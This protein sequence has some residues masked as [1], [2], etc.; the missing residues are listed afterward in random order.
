[1][2]RAVAWQK[3]HH[4][5]P[6][7]FVRPENI[8]VTL[9]PPWREEDPARAA[10]KVREAI[11]GISPFDLSFTKICAGPNRREPRLIWTEAVE[12][13]AAAELKRRLNAALQND[14]GRPYRP[15]VT[16]GRLKT[17]YNSDVLAR[18]A[19]EE[20]SWPERVSSV[21]LFETNSDGSPY[22]VLDAISLEEKH[23]G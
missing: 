10:A 8:H 16:L 1:M 5:V 21:T 7:R 6:L 3:E 13:E 11:R 9:V 2:E 12:S 18:F 23:H 17:G 14:D 15:H 22:T 19:G 20:I 4:S